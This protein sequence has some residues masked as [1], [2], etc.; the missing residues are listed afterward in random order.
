MLSKGQLESY[1]EWPKSVDKL[2]GTAKDSNDILP[3]QFVLRPCSI[4]RKGSR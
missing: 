1:K 4:H 2:E 3:M